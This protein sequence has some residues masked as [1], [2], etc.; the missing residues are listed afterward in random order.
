MCVN[1]E[2]GFKNGFFDETQR[3]PVNR[4]KFTKLNVNLVISRESS[5]LSYLFEIYNH[6]EKEKMLEELAKGIYL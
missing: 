6:S 4:N 3:P 2:D 5:T 1:W